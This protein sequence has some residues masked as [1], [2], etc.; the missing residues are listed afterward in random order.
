VNLKPLEIKSP[1]ATFLPLIVWVYFGQISFIS[2]EIR[3]IRTCIVEA[4]VA[5]QCHLR[6]LLLAPVK[7]AYTNSY[8]WSRVIF[9]QHRTVSDTTT[10]WSK[11][12]N[13]LFSVILV[14]N[15]SDFGRIFG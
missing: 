4:V 8:Q 14:L 1:W 9:L 5:V 3:V 15:P 12:V 2:S 10:S 13:Y 11:I 6:S 7:S